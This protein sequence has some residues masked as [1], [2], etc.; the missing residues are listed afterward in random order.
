M[1]S[2]KKLRTAIIGAE[3]AE[4]ITEVYIPKAIKEK[5]TELTDEEVEQVAQH[6]ILTLATQGQD[7]VVDDSGNRLL[8]LANK[9]V[10]INDLSINLIESINPFQRAYEIISKSLTPEVLHTIQYE[11]ESKREG[12]TTEEAVILFSKYLPKWREEHD[13]RLPT[14]NEPDANGRRIA[15]AIEHLKKLKQQSL[16][17]KK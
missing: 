6:T 2:D 15:M 3:T 16:I 9:F 5:Y 14:L 10:N 17:E 11:I 1:L 7:T 4:M 12:M 13:G 8:R